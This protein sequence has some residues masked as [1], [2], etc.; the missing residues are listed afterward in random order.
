[1]LMRQYF[2]WHIAFYSLSLNAFQQYVPVS[3]SLFLRHNCQMLSLAGIPSALPDV[4]RL[5]LRTSGAENGG[6][7]VAPNAP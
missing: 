5:R 4:P 1:M 3:L 7:Y 2:S 6:G